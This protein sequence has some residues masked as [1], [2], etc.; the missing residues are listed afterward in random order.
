ML[1]DQEAELTASLDD[2]VSGKA[3][4][5]RGEARDIS[6]PGS[7]PE[8]LMLMPYG[9]WANRGPAEMSVWLR[10]LEYAV[11]DTG[12]AGG[13][14]FFVNPNWAADGWRYLEAA[15]NDQSAGAPWGCFRTEIAGARGTAV[16]TGRQN[17]RDILSASGAPGSAA[18]LSASY[19]LNGIGG[20]FLPS[21]DELAQMYR[22][23]KL[24]GVGDF[25]DHGILDNLNYWSSS[26]VSADMARHLDFADNGLRWHY[27]D[28]DYPRRVRAIRAF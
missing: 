25:G 12:P 1:C 2:T 15:P 20:W 13:V 6:R 16:G 9:L 4:V 5:I 14:I 26:Q 27:D 17:T 18:E 24:A 22:N 3:I 21:I 23:L 11:G 19:R 8:P 10:T 7:L 28:K